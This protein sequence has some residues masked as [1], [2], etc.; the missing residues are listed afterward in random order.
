MKVWT[1][2]NVH[3][4]GLRRNCWR[5]FVME[6]SWAV[7]GHEELVLNWSRDRVVLFSGATEFRLGFAFWGYTPHV[8]A[9][10]E[11]VVW[12]DWDASMGKEQSV[13]GVGYERVAGI[14]ETGLWRDWSRKVSHV[15]G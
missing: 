1:R 8:F 12:I 4:E 5:M 6:G 14:R 10:S 2:F 7:I 13:E 15:A 3:G 11:K 9:K